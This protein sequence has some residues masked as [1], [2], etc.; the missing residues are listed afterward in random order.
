MWC[1]SCEAS[2]PLWSATVRGMSFEERRRKKERKENGNQGNGKPF[3]YTFKSKGLGA[4]EV[5]WK[6]TVDEVDRSTDEVQ[7]EVQTK[8]G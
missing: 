7:A 8:D 4:G 3:L 6:K 5:L 2:T 1:G